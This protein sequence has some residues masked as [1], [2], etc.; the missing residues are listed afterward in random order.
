VSLCEEVT[1]E[2]LDG[3]LGAKSGQ[4]GRAEGRRKR[5]EGSKEGRGWS[6][7]RRK[8]KDSARVLRHKAVWVY[9]SIKQSSTAGCLSRETGK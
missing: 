4:G 7:K 5:C 2:F 6:E 9:W 3:P 1:L 8:G